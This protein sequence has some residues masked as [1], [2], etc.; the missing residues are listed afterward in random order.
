M[1]QALGKAALDE[2]Q[3]RKSLVG[4]LLRR[5]D[6]QNLLERPASAGHVSG[7]PRGVSFEQPACTAIGEQPALTFGAFV[8]LALPSLGL[9]FRRPTHTIADLRTDPPASVS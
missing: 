5:P 1:R 4:G 9:L 8:A 7:V 2:A 3:F 6:P